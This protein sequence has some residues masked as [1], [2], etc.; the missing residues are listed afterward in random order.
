MT[1]MIYMIQLGTNGLKKDKEIYIMK[2]YLTHLAATS[3][4]IL[5]EASNAQV[6][7]VMTEYGLF[8]AYYTKEDE[9]QGYIYTDANAELVFQCKDNGI[10]LDIGAHVGR[11]SIPYSMKN[12]TFAFEPDPY[13]FEHLNRNIAN[14]PLISP[15][16]LAIANYVGTGKLHRS[17]RRLEHS[18]MDTHIKDKFL[19]DTIDVKVTTIDEFFKDWKEEPIVGIKIDVEGAES[20]VIE[21]AINILRKYH[22]MLAIE[23]HEQEEDDIMIATLE[24]LG[25]KVQ[26]QLRQLLC[27]YCKED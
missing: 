16:Q 1:P 17:Q 15:H 6:V 22:P 5:A 23:T 18:L 2:T 3:G 21:G 4:T 11:Y 12:R 19:V 10:L 24:E 13:N 8:W 14:H 26:G 27:R 7:E 20:L 25:Y 9:E